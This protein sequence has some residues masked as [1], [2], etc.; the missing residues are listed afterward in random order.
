MERLIR[1]VGGD[2]ICLTLAP[3][4]NSAQLSNPESQLSQSLR[5]S[6]KTKG[7]RHAVTGPAA[8]QGLP[9]LSF[10]RIPRVDTLG[11]L[12]EADESENDDFVALYNT[13]KAFA[14]AY[15]EGDAPKIFG[16]GSAFAFSQN[17]NRG[18][19]LSDNPSSHRPE[20][21][22]IPSVRSS[23]FAC[24]VSFDPYQAFFQWLFPML[25]G[26][27]V[28]FVFPEPSLM[29]HLLDTYFDIHNIILPILHRPTFERSLAD[30]LHERNESFGAV[31]LLT[32]A[33]ACRHS[34]DP[35]VT[36]PITTSTSNTG[37]NLFN[38]VDRLRRKRLLGHQLHDAQVY[39][40]RSLPHFGD[41]Y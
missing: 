20:F 10:P 15:Q 2:V 9:S 17:L 18:S 27:R 26:P 8:E 21:W 35:R 31:V 13:S 33:I 25:N 24:D 19:P 14:G 22:T 28:L 32:C 37:W 12:P 29:Q 1:D 40:V 34:D 7:K 41:T 23:R 11:P 16:E 5:E 30:K 39:A 36:H 3:R 4:L 38:Q 6:R